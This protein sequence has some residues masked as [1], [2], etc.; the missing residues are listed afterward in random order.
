MATSKNTKSYKHIMQLVEESLCIEAEAAK[1]AGALG[2]M[3]RALT[4]ATMPHKKTDET[5]FSR[6][7][8]SFEMSIVALGKY[9]LPYG[10][11]PRLLMAW[12]TTEAVRTKNRDLVLGQS[13][14]DFMRELDMVPTG[15]R[16][17][18]ITR[19][20]E[21]MNRLFSSAVSARYSDDTR[22]M[23]ANFVLAEKYDLWWH[24][25][26]VETVSMWESK[27]LLSQSFYDEITQAPVPID[28]RVL[29]AL[30]RSPMALDIYPWLTYRLSYLKRTTII[31]WAALQLQFGADYKVTRQFKAAF[32]EHL[33]TVLLMYTEAKVQ[34]TDAGLELR[35]SP[36]HIPFKRS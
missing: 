34:P 33:K 8:G 9:G 20:R 36:P 4:Q 3:A 30:R 27:L 24:P 15:G 31:P 14:S 32:I 18:S 10:S 17:G 23:G 29:K 26:S 25:K 35:P 22:D 5:R 12:V 19:L 11:I 6:V 28:L 16:W 21:Q 13:L 7:N 1:E 2:F